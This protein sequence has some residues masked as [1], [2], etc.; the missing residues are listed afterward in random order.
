MMSKIAISLRPLT[1]D[2]WIECIGLQVTGEQEAQD[3][4]APNLYSIAE[5]RFEPTWTPFVVYAGEVMVGFV[6]YD[7]SD[8]EIT[9]LMIDARYQGRGYGRAAMQLLIELME[10]EYAHPSASTSFVPGN[11]VAERLYTSLG[12]YKT[13]EILDGEIVM[14][15][16][17]KKRAT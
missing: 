1:A 15:R 16:T 14:V 10:R 8:Y 2:N 9:R 6:M 7:T 5:T 17:L 4:V 12:F 11:L 13:G 3:F